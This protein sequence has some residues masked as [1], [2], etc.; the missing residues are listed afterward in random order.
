MMIDPKQQ[1]YV[2]VLLTH[3]DCTISIIH[4]DRPHVLVVGIVY[5]FIVKPWRRRIAPELG[6]KVHD[7]ALFRLRETRKSAE[8]V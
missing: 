5:F 8:E 3:N 2:A 6:H 4:T 1:E 7:F